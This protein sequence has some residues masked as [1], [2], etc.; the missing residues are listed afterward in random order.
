[1]GEVALIITRI[2][3]F[4]N[5]CT[6]DKNSKKKDSRFPD[7]LFFG[8]A[9]ECPGLWRRDASLILTHRFVFYTLVLLP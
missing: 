9:A 8:N 1:M 2:M 6:L 5:P 4:V 3:G 7:K